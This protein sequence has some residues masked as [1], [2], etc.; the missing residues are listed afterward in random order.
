MMKQWEKE[1]IL[2][3]GKYSKRPEK[4][5]EQVTGK[6]A[7]KTPQVWALYKEVQDYYDKGMRVPG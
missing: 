7:E 3:C 5:I 1:P 2:L 6:K 4:I